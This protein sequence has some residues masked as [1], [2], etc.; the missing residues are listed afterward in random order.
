LPTI[1]QDIYTHTPTIPPVHSESLMSKQRPLAQ[2][3]TATGQPYHNVKGEETTGAKR[4]ANITLGLSLGTENLLVCSFNQQYTEGQFRTVPCA[5]VNANP[6]VKFKMYLWFS[7]LQV[8]SAGSR[9]CIQK[10]ILSC[11]LV[12]G[13]GVLFWCGHG[14]I[15]NAVSSDKY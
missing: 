15:Q 14:I 10:L 11:G 13:F 9:F 2:G 12:C 5:T 8:R 3:E 1:I 7:C 4:K 6:W